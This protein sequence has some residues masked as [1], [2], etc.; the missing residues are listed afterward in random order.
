MDKSGSSNTEITIQWSAVTVGVN[1]GGNGVAISGY[2]IEWDGGSVTQAGTSF[3]QS[4][5]TPNTV[6]SFRVAAINEYG[7]GTYSDTTSFKTG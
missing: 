4:S 7:T 2:T 5:L 3:Y 1:S 6:Y